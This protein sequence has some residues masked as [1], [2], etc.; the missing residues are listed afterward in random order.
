MP[1][2]RLRSH[3]IVKVVQFLLA[4]KTWIDA[5]CTC[6]W[7]IVDI[8]TFSHWNS[9]EYFQL[10][11]LS[12]IIWRFF[13]RSISFFS[14]SH[15]QKAAINFNPVCVFL[16][17]IFENAKNNEQRYHRTTYGIN[18]KYVY[19][20][21]WNFC[22]FRAKQVHKLNNLALCMRAHTPTE[23][24]EIKILNESRTC[25]F[26][27]RQKTRTEKQATTTRHTSNLSGLVIALIA[28]FVS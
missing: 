28:V 12:A 25:E 17:L 27:T 6:E 4:L 19:H 13:S 3:L 9:T 14:H 10:K 16:S 11:S 7:V 20:L 5:N 22:I 2:Q 8:Y 1:L 26:E 24:H 15:D 18:S 23:I 21:H